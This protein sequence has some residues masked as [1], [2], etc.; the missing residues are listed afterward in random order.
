MYLYT[1]FLWHIGVL[2][3]MTLLV[4][5]CIKKY[6]H[7]EQLLVGDDDSPNS[8]ARQRGSGGGEGRGGRSKKSRFDRSSHR[9]LIKGITFDSKGTP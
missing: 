5:S 6:Q 1:L 8:L 7:F 4:F 2:W 3:N 9:S